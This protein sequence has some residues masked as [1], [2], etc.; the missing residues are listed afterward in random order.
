M[1]SGAAGLWDEGFKR[2]VFCSAIFGLTALAQVSAARSAWFNGVPPKLSRDAECMLRV[3]KSAPGIDRIKLGISREDWPH[4]YLQYRTA[5][6]PNGFRTTLRFE[7]LWFPHLGDAKSPFHVVLPGA[8]P[9]GRAHPP[10]F[11]AGAMAS[12]WNTKCDVS[13]SVLFE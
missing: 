7:A 1:I 3:L 9:F 2:W 12:L 4:P 5:P 11:G 8:V 13:V 6:E 10:D